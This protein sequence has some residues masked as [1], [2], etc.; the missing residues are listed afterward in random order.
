VTLRQLMDDHLMVA[1]MADRAQQVVRGESA[2]L[3]RVLSAI[4][5]FIDRK[6]EGRSSSDPA[7]KTADARA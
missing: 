5:P 7:I 2:V 4:M 3:H 1:K 6:L